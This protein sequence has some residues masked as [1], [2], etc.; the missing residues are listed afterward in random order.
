MYIYDIPY[1]KDGQMA[2]TVDGSAPINVSK[3]KDYLVNKM[4]AH[5]V[6]M[7]ETLGSWPAAEYEIIGTDGNVIFRKAF[8]EGEKTVAKKPYHKIKKETINYVSKGY[9]NLIADEDGNIMTDEE[10]LAI[11]YS[12]IYVHRLPIGASRQVAVQLATYKPVTKREFLLLKGV[13][14]KI[15]EKCGESLMEVIRAYLE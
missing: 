14:E 7:Y 3:K 11:L 9:F 8:L 13:G 6:S 5:R 2:L 10:L 12:F 1:Q 15:Y 4:H